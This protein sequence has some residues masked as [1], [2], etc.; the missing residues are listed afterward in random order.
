MAKQGTSAKVAL[1]AKLCGLPVTAATVEAT[2]AQKQDKD[3]NNQDRTHGNLPTA[4]AV[5]NI[6]AV[7]LTSA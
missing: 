4:K 6:Q 2:T 1:S 5:L 7:S 3:H